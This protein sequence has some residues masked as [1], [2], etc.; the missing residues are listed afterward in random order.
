MSLK[1]DIRFLKNQM[2]APQFLEF[3]DAPKDLEI[4]LSV[5]FKEKF[6][7]NMLII[8][9]SVKRIF[10]LKIVNLLMFLLRGYE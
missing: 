8:S 2:H 9:V 3:K 4:L 1:K 5:K 10:F 6:F 7:L